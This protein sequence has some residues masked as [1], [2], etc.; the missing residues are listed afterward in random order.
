MYAT[1]TNCKYHSDGKRSKQIKRYLTVRQLDTLNEREKIK[2]G[3]E[4]M[5]LLRLKTEVTVL[6]TF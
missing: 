1:R 2:R 6:S 3:T 5:L 4:K